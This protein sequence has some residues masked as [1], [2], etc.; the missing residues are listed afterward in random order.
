MTVPH[1]EPGIAPGGS[2]QEQRECKTNDIAEPAD[3]K[4][5]E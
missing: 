2:K 5:E 1:Q 4:H 3:D